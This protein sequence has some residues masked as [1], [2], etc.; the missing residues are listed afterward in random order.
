RIKARCPTERHGKNGAVPVNHIKGEE[1]GNLHPRLGHGNPLKLVCSSCAAHVE[2]R[3]EQAFADQLAMLFTKSPI[4]VAVELLK[5]T[6][7]FFQCHLC[8]QDVDSFLD[9]VPPLQSRA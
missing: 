1:Y 7:F 4:R 6:E 2:R 9:F 5:L 3:A 8:K